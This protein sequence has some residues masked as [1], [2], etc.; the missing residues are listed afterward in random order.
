MGCGTSKS[1]QTIEN[2]DIE[3]NSITNGNVLNKE[4]ANNLTNGT[5]GST[6]A[7]DARRMSRPMTPGM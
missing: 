2:T 6:T 1:V 7:T 5:N 3:S 4:N